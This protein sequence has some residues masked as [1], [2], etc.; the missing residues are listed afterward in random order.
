MN[1]YE[2]HKDGYTITT[3]QAKLDVA[4]IHKYLSEES[5]WSKGI[6]LHIVQKSVANSLSFGVLHNGQ[7]AGFARLVTDKATFA[8]LADVFI[9]TP[10]RGK[11]LSKWL[12]QAIHAHPDVDG[13]RRWLLVTKDADTLYE[14]F[15]WVHVP[16][17]TCSRMMQK[18]VPDIY[19]Q[20]SI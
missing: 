2:L 3:S 11:G 15:G 1:I 14:K 19:Q 12:M 5:Y 4:A 8:Y 17:E 13:L 9:L 20:S 6:P 7:L 10:H 16:E 18:H